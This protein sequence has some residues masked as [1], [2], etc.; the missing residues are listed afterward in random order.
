MKNRYLI[1]TLLASLILA[2]CHKEDNLNKE[3]KVTE[4][5]VEI[6]ATQAT[7]SWSVDWPGRL[8]SVVE[9]SENA[10]MSAS[11][12]FGSEAETESHEFSATAT[13]LKP[14]AKYYY[15]Y[16]VWN[17]YYENDKFLMEVK[18]FT[19]YA[20]PTVITTEVTEISW[21]TVTC[22][23]EVT[24]DGNAPDTE[25][26]VCWSTNHNPE[27][28][29]SHSSNGT[30]MGNYTVDVTGL[31]AGTT[32]YVR[33]YA[34][35]KAGVGYGEE[36]SFKTRDPE[37]PTVTTSAVIN[38]SNTSAT[39]GGNVT[40]DGGAE[41]TE[42]GVCWSTSHNPEITDSHARRGTGMGSYTVNMTGLTEGTSYYVRAY[43]VNSEGTSYGNEVNFVSCFEGAVGGLF[44][45]SSSE[46]VFFS[47]GNLQYRAFDERWRFAEQQYNYIGSANSNISSSYNGW[48]D[49]FGWGTSGWNSGAV[50]YQPWSRST[51]YS[52]YYPG[53]SYLNDLTGNCANADWGV[54]NKISNGGNEAGLWRTLTNDEWA[55]VFKTRN[56][57]SG[58]RYAKACVN[59][60][61]GVILLPDDWNTSYYSLSSTNIAGASFTSNTLSTSQ[62]STLEQ[63]G[64]VF[65]PAAGDRNGSSVFS[66]GSDGEYWSASYNNSDYAYHV[67]FDDSGLFTQGYIYRDYGQSVRLVR[68][69]Q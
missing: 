41:V 13:G 58:I 5:S 45:V 62:W 29:D 30:G 44:S 65:L 47:K 38:I 52:D 37:P 20:K 6:F 9:L 10:D 18:R 69:T 55:Y 19:T 50:C 15:R 17:R 68:D 66:V 3:P 67:W 49:L 35:N 42:R 46:Q 63:H 64:A 4:A 57:A 11:R 7:F 60:Q 53:G 48:I 26:G 36:L 61:N 22:G 43:A 27:I 21:R 28:S 16:V 56:T 40:S 31:T 2:A 12:Y 24:Y 39:G 34:K 14:D 1:I 25:R 32:Y 54:Y 33:A 8:N 23:G 59:N 51:A